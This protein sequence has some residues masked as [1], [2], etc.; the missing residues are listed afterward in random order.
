MAHF[1]TTDGGSTLVISNVT[2][3]DQGP[4][5]CHVSNPVSNGT[6]GPVDLTIN[7]DR[8][9]LPEVTEEELEERVLMC[10]VSS[11]SSLS[12]LWLNSSS[13]VTA[14]DRVHTTDEGSTLIIIGVTR[15]DQGPF[16]CHAFNPV[17]NG[18]SDP[19]NFVISY[20]PSNAMMTLLPMKLAYRT[21][22]NITLSCSADSS[23]AARIWWMFDGMDLDKTGPQLH[24][25]N[26]T[27]S[28]SG[29]Y[30]CML[31][32]NVTSRFSSES[33]MIRILSK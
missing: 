1:H 23:P 12:F 33:K 13:E 32:N 8:L 20:G 18:T 19:V 15:Y 6:S 28:N 5:R 26:V 9:P 2:R 4:F 21:G 16:R 27:E 31:H 29:N 17:S 24:L 10:S 25:Q 14:S 30:T 22:D 7:C 11:G 3:Y